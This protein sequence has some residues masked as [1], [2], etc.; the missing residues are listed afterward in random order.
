[1]TKNNTSRAWAILLFVVGFLT[2]MPPFARIFDTTDPISD[3]G[4]PTL[5]TYL[6]VIWIA[7]ILMAWRLSRRLEHDQMEHGKDTEQT[8]GR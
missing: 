1:M 2:L 8:G 5:Y 6:F 4:V 3:F 7:L